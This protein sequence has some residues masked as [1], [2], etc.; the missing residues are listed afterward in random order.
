[1]K[2]KILLIASFFAILILLLGCKGSI[3]VDP[4]PVTVPP[5]VKKY[6]VDINS[7]TNGVINPSGKIEVI[8]GNSLNL[9]ITPKFG[10]K[11]DTFLVNQF[12]VIVNGNSYSLNNVDK[13]YQI[14]ATYV[15]N[16]SWY[17]TQG[18]WKC[19]S[20]SLLEPGSIWYN[21]AMWGISGASQFV[22]IFL[23]DGTYELYES[24]KLYRSGTWSIS[25]EDTKSASLTLKMSIGSEVWKIEK[26]DVSNLILFRDDVPLVGNPNYNYSSERD[27]YSQLK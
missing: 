15:K 18:K 22:F 16:L 9:S 27:K 24:G 14:K 6:T 12:P 3:V 21:Y 1:M 4:T 17:L 25:G 13:N 8:S 20:V 23:P 10:Y 5:I 2:K 26:L 19:D 11:L 7:D